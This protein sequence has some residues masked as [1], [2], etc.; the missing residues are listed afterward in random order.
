M[1]LPPPVSRL[2][3]LWLLP[4]F[5][6]AWPVLAAEP[7]TTAVR[8]AALKVG[9]GTPE[10]TS[11]L[12]SWAQEVR[13][14]TSID[15]AATPAAVR[16]ED[17]AIF[18][19]PL[20]Y[21]SGDRAVPPL[22]ELAIQHLRQHLSTGGMLIIDNGGRSEPSAAFDT[23]VRRELARIFPQALQKVPASH[24]I[25]R[26]FYRLERP[27]GRRADS[28]DLEGLRVGAHFAVLYS[29]NDMGGALARLPLGGY[30]LA[31]VPGGELQREQ[32]TRLAINLVMYALCLDYKD[33]HSHVMHLLRQRRGLKG[34][35]QPPRPAQDPP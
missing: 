28:H 20:L 32:A 34:T 16:P 5:L 23:S 3:P 8:I 4:L 7:P 12:T 6:M 9:P 25:F 1:P 22:S 11:A 33:D 21:W 35:T 18:A 17:H 2:L 26:S 15:V 19:Y 13:L 24:V 14:R 30:A 10:V 29:R 31:V 27:V